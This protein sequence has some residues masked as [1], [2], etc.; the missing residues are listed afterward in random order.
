M[1]TVDMVDEQVYK[2][3]KN[4]YKQIAMAMQY[5]IE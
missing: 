5:T 3:A 2:E 1:H 4:M